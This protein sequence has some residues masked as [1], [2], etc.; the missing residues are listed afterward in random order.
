MKVYDEIG[1]KQT[2]FIRAQR[3]FF[4]ATAPLAADGHV[5]LSPKGYEAFAIL[6]P[7]R[8]AY[9]DLG[10][11]GIETHAHL[12]E[13]GRI[14][15]MFCAFEGNPLILRLYGAG[16]SHAH[17]MPEFDA[18]RENF[19]GVE[20]PV[21]GIIEVEVTRVQDSCGFG[22]PL[23]EYQGDRDRLANH[24][25]KLGQEALMERRFRTNAESI[26][27]LP[28]LTRAPAKTR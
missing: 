13:N 3:M 7:R 5:N 8:V 22:V 4:V 17:G 26:D 6:G 2:A 28:G 18:L 11:S 24:N 15:L 23:Y 19:P 1:V 21:R 20:V 16:R 25:A 12:N 9:I 10:G 14:C 27:G